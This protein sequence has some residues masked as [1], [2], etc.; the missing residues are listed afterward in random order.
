MGFIDSTLGKLFGNK[1]DRDLKEL[2]P[3]LGKIK[4]EYDR[5]TTLSND[6][7]R[8]ES[9][10]LKQRI[11]DFIQAEKDEI[12]SLKDKVDTGE[13]SINEREEIYDRIDEIEKKIDEKIEEVLDEILPTAFAVIKDTARR[14]TENS[15]LEVTASKFDRDLAPYYDNI[16]I[17]GDTAVYFNSWVA[18]GTEIT[19]NMI[20]YDV[21]LI[22]GTVLHQGKIAE[23]ATGEG[24]T[25]VA[26]LPVFLNALTGR[27]VHLIT[28]NDYL[29]KRDSEWMGPI[30][31]F[32][33]L[34]V[35]CID[36]HSPNSDARR[37]A[38]ASDIT[39]GTNN[40]FGFDYLRDNMAT[41]PKDLVQRR[42]NYSIV[43]EVDSVLV[44]DA[45]TP[46][47]ISGPIP[48]GE[49]QQF[50]DLKPKVQKLVKAQNDLVMKIFTDSKKLLNSEDKKDLEE[51]AKL[52]LR[53][54]KG[55]PKMKPLIK[56]LSE[57]GNKANLLKT[58]N[59]YMQENNK[60][61]HIITDELYFV[62]DE[63]H[64]SI[65]LTD[66]G[67]DLISSD[68]EDSGFFV[69]PDIGSEVAVIEK[70]D[71]SEEEKVAKKDEMIQAYSVRSERVH[72]INQLLKA[73]TLFEK[74]VEYVMMDGK[75]KIVDE[76]TGRIMEGR[77]YSDGLHQAIEAKENVKVEAATQTFATIT[78]QNY[79]RM[80]NKLAGMTGTAETEAGELWDIYKLEVVVIPTNR[81]ICRDDRED[82]VYKT[83]REK[84]SAVIDEIVDLVNAGRPVL[85]GTTSVEISELLG[86]M[87]KI[88][89][90]KHNVLNAKLHQREADIVAEAG[91]SGTVTI[92]TNMA[93]RGTDIKL[94][95][96]VKAAGGLAIIGTERHDSRR[97]DRQLRGRAGRQGDI[98][99]SQFFVSLEDDLMRLFS[100]DRIVK[101]M[102]RMGLKEGEVIQHS[103]ITK[104]IERAQ[105]KVEE[106]NF[107]I[108]KRLLEY[109]DVMNSQREVIYKRRRH[110]LFGE[111]IQVDIANMMYDISELIANEYHGG[112]F[113][114]FK[115]DLL[116]TFSTESPVSEE[117]FMKEKPE[118]ITEKIY[119]VV[120]DNYKRKVE[121]ISKQAY[122]V[123]KNVYESKAE[124]YENI[125][126]P[127]SDGSKMFQVVT[128]LK[129]AYESKAE[130]LVRSFEKVSILA[131]IDDAWKEHLREMDDLK[132]SVQNA[133]Y[134]Q[135]DPLLIYKFESFNLFKTMIETINKS[136][137]SSLMKG[138][139]PLS[140]PEDV[141]KAEERKRTDLSNLKTTKE[142][143]GGGRERPEP[144]KPEPVRV[145]QKV[146]RNEPCPCGSGKK[147]KQCHGKGVPA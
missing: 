21:Q 10:K 139:I 49:H 17:D 122:P 96:E 44:D 90:I 124:I 144:K 19:W 84:Y 7:L 75:V 135:K 66:K 94:S 47:I 114:E 50:D 51:G 112:D 28:V 119:A 63:K 61:M 59:F 88:K 20:H 76:Q 87:L 79:F 85:V 42:H 55:L 23:M 5:V 116:R 120:L 71:L 93:G 43:D 107:G 57:Q 32:H 12:Q 37:K 138:H 83:K 74:D 117:E 34:S 29:A 134:E 132:Q 109:D 4:A 3:Y 128:N 127:F 6:D 68:V 141:R 99:S 48:R 82:L 30:Y 35:D 64:N 129:K 14:F 58:E 115:M 77:R 102:D 60:N 142:E 95:D 2:S 104:S 33:G 125:V 143:V 41:N 9:D 26:T 54:Y 92:A 45:R 72:T 24:K 126:V 67:I 113:E 118:E 62:I 38:Y 146:G 86:R 145:A 22:G 103:M 140:D 70:S 101:L 13:L 121:A 98:G 1:S 100:S 131:T 105:K 91:Q 147:F 16:Q 130:D 123:I 31:Q 81:P 106:N 56:F 46:L 89:G 73:Y 80:Y 136:V 18:G 11:Q 78:L 53:T 69:L 27:G 97:V 110:A 39:F 40:E 15:E 52:L 25:L 133:S 108:R 111:R 137:V 36:K 8:G 65:E